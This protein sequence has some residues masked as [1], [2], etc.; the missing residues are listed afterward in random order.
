ME[1]ANVIY[2]ELRE[3]ERLRATSVFGGGEY[4]RERYGQDYAQFNKDAAARNVAIERT[5]ILRDVDQFRE[6]LPIME[7][8]SAFYDIRVLLVS[9][10]L[11]NDRD[12]RDFFVIDRELAVEFHFNGEVITTIDVVSNG[13][14]VIEFEKTMDRI[15][16][17]AKP[18]KD[19]IHR[20]A[21]NP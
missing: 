1:L 16:S 6:K 2:K 4:W 5:Y 8:Q 14:E 11:I 15:V 10:A 12:R 20:F 19:V 17:A 3:R 7:A 13:D 9:D 18:L 21:N